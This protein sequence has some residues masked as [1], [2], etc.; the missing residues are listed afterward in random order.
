[1]LAVD[2]P[3]PPGMNLRQFP[4][5][6]YTFSAASTLMPTAIWLVLPRQSGLT[7]AASPDV[8]DPAK[9]DKEKTPPPPVAMYRTELALFSAIPR[10][11]PEKKLPP[12]GHDV[13]GKKAGPE[14]EP[15]TALPTTAR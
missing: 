14:T 15:V 9:F 1:M 4:M 3:V 8:G 5:A 13:L 7:S 11:K 6:R 10:G 12:F 2:D